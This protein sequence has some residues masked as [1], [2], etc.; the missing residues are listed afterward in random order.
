MTLVL[1]ALLLMSGQFVRGSGVSGSHITMS[2]SK[3]FACF[4]KFLV[5]DDFD[6]SFLVYS[7]FCLKMVH[8]TD[9][10]EAVSAFQTM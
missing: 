3:I 1:P 9:D 6:F 8:T 2:V 5:H 10:P 4:C 7:W